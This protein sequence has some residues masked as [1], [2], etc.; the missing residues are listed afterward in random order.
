MDRIPIAFVS[1]RLHEGGAITFLVELGKELQERGFPVKVFSTTSDNAYAQDFVAAG[2]EVT[3]QDDRGLIWED[4]VNATLDAIRA[5]NPAVYVAVHG[6]TPFEIA[7][8]LP[9]RMTKIGMIHIDHRETH[10]SLSRFA[11]HFD[12]FICVSEEI[13]TELAAILP[14]RPKLYS[15]KCGVAIPPDPVPHPLSATARILYYGRLERPQKR[16]HL[17]PE[18][19]RDL[20]ASGIPFHW[21][22]AG[23]GSE[24]ENLRA[25]LT[26]SRSDQQ[27]EVI[28]PV[29]YSDVSRLLRQNDLYLLASDAE[30]LPLTLL[31][32]MAHGLVPVITHLA[33]GVTEVVNES[34]GRLVAVDDISGY[35]RE[36]VSLHRDPE[37]M[38]RLSRNARQIVSEKFSTMASADRWVAMLD[39]LKPT[40]PQWPSNWKIATPL[41]VN[42]PLFFSPP[43]RVLRRLVKRIAR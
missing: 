37:A 31:E 43:A 11:S 15:I 26:T 7:R 32:A 36:I 27:V 20:I 9:A 30:G 25:S 41:G 29:A 38:Q 2:L 40:Q 34:T 22:I 8:S 3:T 5:F 24:L 16:V 23:G 10:Q 17:F 14:E 28:G 4:R 33:S 21:T 18:I 42:N 35:A 12:A 6:A 13:R 1:E 19:L 39:E